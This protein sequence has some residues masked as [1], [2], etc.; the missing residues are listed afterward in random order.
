MKL[1]NK[2]EDKTVTSKTLL[3]TSHSFPIPSHC[4]SWGRCLDWRQWNPPQQISV[5]SME[6]FRLS[7]KTS[8]FGNLE[9]REK[10]ICLKWKHCLIKSTQRQ[11]FITR[12]PNCKWKLQLHLLDKHGIG[13]WNIF[14]SSK[15][16]TNMNLKE[17]KYPGEKDWKR[18]EIRSPKRFF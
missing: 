8:N 7:S 15:V 6:R 13:K 1:R 4:Q 14:K 12:P 17:M 18:F 10:R 3:V 9:E 11:T 5:I 2:E 16:R